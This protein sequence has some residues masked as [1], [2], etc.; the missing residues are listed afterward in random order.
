MASPNLP[1]ASPSERNMFAMKN[2]L[3]S[4]SALWKSHPSSSGL[5]LQ[6]SLPRA[7]W[8]ARA[9]A[10]VLIVNVLLAWSLLFLQSCS[11]LTG[12]GNAPKA[13][14]T[15][16]HGRTT[17]WQRVP[18]TPA[19]QTGSF[20][21]VAVISPNDAWAVGLTSHLSSTQA[22]IEHWNG[23][24][25]KV[26]PGAEVKDN[27]N[28]LNVVSAISADDVWAAGGKRSER[29]LLE[30][31]DGTHWSSVPGPAALDTPDFFG[32]S[33]LA[34]ISERDVWVV[35]KSRPS[36]GPQFAHWDGSAWNIIA[37]P[38]SGEMR[39]L[40]ALSANNIWGV[41][42]CGTNSIIPHVLIE[43]WDG[44][45]WSWMPSPVPPGSDLTAITAAA[46]NDIWAVGNTRPKNQSGPLI[47]HWNGVS[48]S[49]VPSLSL[50]SQCGGT[51]S[52]NGGAAISKENIWIIGSTS[53]GSAERAFFLHWN[54]KSWSTVNIPAANLYESRLNDVQ[55]ISHSSHLWAVGCSTKGADQD[56]Q[57]LALLLS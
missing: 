5:L 17:A 49:I 36:R 19:E 56:E 48:W 33:A 30:H 37:G 45:Q 34:A 31:W 29:F 26:V 18:V 4:F 25:W 41:G 14:P 32:V 39:R 27:P 21:A 16:T 8:F 52:L 15:A 11:A 38:C 54:G 24:A 2:P 23:S 10:P 13:P 40:Q 44:K 20:N 35:V 12:N 46:A 50:T 43:H 57:P 51:C 42:Y 6:R 47:L 22:L 9:L 55:Q 28:A 1:V 53:F 3:L 7:S